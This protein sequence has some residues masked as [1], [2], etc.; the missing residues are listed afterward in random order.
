MLKSLTSKL[1]GW[2][3]S[4]GPSISG[5]AA[6]VGG[7]ASSM[8]SGAGSLVSGSSMAR[9]GIASAVKFG[10]TNPG[11]VGMGLGGIGGYMASGDIGGA[12]MGAAA[13]GIGGRA[14]WGSYQQKVSRQSGGMTSYFSRARQR[15]SAKAGRGITKFAPDMAKAYGPQ[16]GTTRT[17]S[18]IRKVFAGQS[19]NLGGKRLGGQ[20]V[21]A[22][23]MMGAGIAA[24]SAYGMGSAIAGSLGNTFGSQVRTSYGNGFSGLGNGTISGY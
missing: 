23:M 24:G 19:R 7:R 17:A 9:K 2:L 20:V 1:S 18:G 16:I 22:G 11:L 12:L 14:G 3:G 13:G 5:A 21:G 4:A 10:A 15:L 6:S 8:L